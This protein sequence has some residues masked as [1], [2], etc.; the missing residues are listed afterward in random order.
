MNAAVIALAT[1]RATATVVTAAVAA[2]CGG[3]GGEA[4]EAVAALASALARV[5]AR[6]GPSHA[7]E[8]HHFALSRGV[9]AP[10]VPDDA[11]ALVARLVD[12]LA[13]AAAGGAG[14]DAWVMRTARV[15][16]CARCGGG[17]S[18]ETGAPSVVCP[19]PFDG[20]G[21]GP[22]SLQAAWE[23]AV[24]CARTGPCARCGA[25]GARERVFVEGA[26]PVVFIHVTCESLDAVRARLTFDEVRRA[27][28]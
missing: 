12:W 10:C 21:G 2:G 20:A 16:E 26:P 5:R 7:H 28:A 18:T 1:V 6:V 4:G 25:A 8:L 19:L 17:V 9:C 27:R 11:G 22:V 13:G 24:A 23:C 15:A 3:C 14:A